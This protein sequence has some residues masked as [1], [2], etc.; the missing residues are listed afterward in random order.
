M[1]RENTVA[2]MAPVKGARKYSQMSSKVLGSLLSVAKSMAMPTAGLKHPPLILLT[3]ALPAAT[4]NPME[5]PVK[6]CGSSL[7]LYRPT[8]C[9]TITR[10]PVYMA[11]TAKALP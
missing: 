7:P 4:T 11:S 9:M 8:A 3:V 2:T 5:M 1:K 6:L 10:A